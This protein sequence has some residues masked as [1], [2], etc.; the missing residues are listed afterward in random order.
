METQSRRIEQKCN[1][2]FYDLLKSNT[3][4]KVHQGGT[5][6]GKTYAICQYI[7]YI[8]TTSKKP[9]VISIIRKTLP[10]LKG[11]VLRDII[12]ILEQTGIYY[13]GI[14]NKACL[15]YTSPSQRDRG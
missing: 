10:A 1:K 3:R 12:T 7:A 9:L 6:S 2:Q 4:F 14:H 11:S 15:L 13:L 5:R 8:L